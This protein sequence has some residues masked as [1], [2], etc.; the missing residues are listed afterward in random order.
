MNISM[1]N[2]VHAHPVRWPNWTWYRP[3]PS[4]TSF[5]VYAVHATTFDLFLIDRHRCVSATSCASW[6]T[7]RFSA[8]LLGFIL[9]GMMEG[10]PARAL[11]IFRFGPIW[12]FSGAAR[13]PW[14]SG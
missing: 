6:I 2:L 4:I 13:L 10:K 1:I 5:G 3:S 14:A 8:L 12:A 11:S 7:S 9:G